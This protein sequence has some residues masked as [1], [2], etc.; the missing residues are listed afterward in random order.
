MVDQLARRPLLLNVPP[1][2][3]RVIR[4]SMT[5]FPH[6]KLAAYGRGLVGF[7]AVNEIARA[8]HDRG[9]FAIASN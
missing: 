6:R 4:V 3:E 9:E 8:A 1:E 5:A 7:G 2:G